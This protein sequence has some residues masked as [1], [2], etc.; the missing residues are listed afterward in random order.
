MSNEREKGR[1]GK[2]IYEGFDQNSPRPPVP[3]E[4]QAQC[5][6]DWGLPQSMDYGR[7]KTASP[8]KKYF[9]YASG[10]TDFKPPMLRMN[11]SLCRKID[12]HGFWA[13]NQLWRFRQPLPPFQT[14]QTRIFHLFLACVSQLGPFLT[15]SA[16]GYGRSGTLQTIPAVRRVSACRR[17]GFLVCLWRFAETDRTRDHPAVRQSDLQVSGRVTRRNVCNCD[18]CCPPQTLF[19]Q[20]CSSHQRRVTKR[21]RKKFE[22][23][24]LLW[25]SVDFVRWGASA[26]G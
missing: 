12:R 26:S 7:H 11:F 5:T 24:N 18:D 16:G 25:A 10:K 15:A 20:V 9:S 21:S 3:G 14:W 17:L 19:P 6:S 13:R 8:S 23:V 22:I 2:F 1:G 4:E